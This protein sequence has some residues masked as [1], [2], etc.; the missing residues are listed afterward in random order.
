ML[1]RDE[2]ALKGDREAPNCNEK[3]LKGY[4]E[5]QKKEMEMC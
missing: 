5:T 2:E 3:A 4:G 1:K